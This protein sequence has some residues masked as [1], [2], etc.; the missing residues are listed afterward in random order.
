M[1]KCC[2]HAK[3]FKFQIFTKKKNMSLFLKTLKTTWTRFK[4]IYEK[5][6]HFFI[7]LS[8]KTKMKGVMKSIIYHLLFSTFPREIPYQGKL[9]K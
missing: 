4:H 3:E 1:V 7:N 9:I 6:N 8:L 5:K 2:N